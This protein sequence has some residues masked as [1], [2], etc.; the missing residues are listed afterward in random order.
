M[1]R[2]INH[3]NTIENV[4]NGNKTELFKDKNG[5][6]DSKVLTNNNVRIYRYC[7]TALG[8]I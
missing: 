4:I 5:F 6:T 7:T 2:S 8:K 3:R 1:W